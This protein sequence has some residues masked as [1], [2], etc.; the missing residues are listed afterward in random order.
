MKDNTPV[1]RVSRE[2]NSE[3]SCSKPEI[4]VPLQQPEIPSASKRGNESETYSV[5][6]RIAP[7]MSVLSSTP[8][9]QDA[10]AMELSL[11]HI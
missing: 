1:M 3:P 2:V 10:E 7:G 11:I 6:I 5:P 4:S 8:A 9:T